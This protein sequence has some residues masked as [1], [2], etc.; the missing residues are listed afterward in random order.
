MRIR[1][2]LP[3][4]FWWWPGMGPLW[5]I[6]YGFS[7]YWDWCLPHKDHWHIGP[8]G[9]YYTRALEEKATKK[10]QAEVAALEAEER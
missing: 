6:R 5:S 4:F 3:V 2:Y 10:W 1:R 9:V 8:V 7:Y